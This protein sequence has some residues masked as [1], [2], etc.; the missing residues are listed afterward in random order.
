M[1]AERKPVEP[2]TLLLLLGGG[3]LLFLVGTICGALI[4]GR[5]IGPESP[6]PAAPQIVIA[7]ATPAP[8]TST[9][10]PG[11]TLADG[12]FCSTTPA[13]WSPY[14]VQP[15][16][17]LSE[18]VAQAGVSQAIVLQANCLTSPELLAGQ[19]L[20]LPP[21]PTP[22]P[23]RAAPPSGWTLYT[24]QMG[25]TLSGL[26]TARQTTVDAVSQVN[27]LTS[28]TLVAGQ[29]LYL[30]A[31]PTPTPCVLSLPSNWGSYTVQ[32]DDTLFS[33]AAA[34]GATVEQVVRVN[35][36]A[37]TEI[38]VGQV[39]YLPL[40]PAPTSTPFA[41]PTPIL[42]P[43]PMAAPVAPSTVVAQAIP[44]M[45]QPAPAAGQPQ[46]PG[47]GGVQSDQMAAAESIFSAPRGLFATRTG[48]PGGPFDP[49]EVTQIE[50][51]PCT[52]ADQLWQENGTPWLVV[53]PE[54]KKQTDMLYEVEQGGRVYIYVCGYTDPTGLKAWIIGPEQIFYPLAVQLYL[55]PAERRYE[56][57]LWTAQGVVVWSTACDL[58]TG[59]YRLFVEN[60]QGLRT[61]EVT[62]ELGPSSKPR[63][64]VVPN[65]T[66]AGQP[67]EFYYCGYPPPTP[68]D[69]SLLAE[70]GRVRNPL[71]MTQ[72]ELL[73]VFSTIRKWTVTPS[74]AQ[75]AKQ[76]FWSSPEDPP[77]RYR[78][79]QTNDQKIY[80]DFW[81]LR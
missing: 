47:L 59:K 74:A 24:V 7:T 11:R 13:D 18:L 25:D 52:E 64:L 16:D 17:T 65:V 66:L 22:G 53:D 56:E 51:P 15:G 5:I 2:R 42:Q 43:T 75:W 79:E 14:T 76:T 69:L 12:T 1:A 26:T 57:K 60:S 23:C 62:F 45:G 78:L 38:Q 34:R 19:A 3:A 44:S 72:K 37:S 70:T 54:T 77:G 71:D 20:Y 30:P 61:E 46:S 80:D 39:L 81:L 10:T 4:W 8:M 21:T 31:L 50:F 63:I 33:L 32:P 36:L 55:S 73:P 29:T 49:K 35:C 6:T 27:C 9:S 41:P 40:L 67:F 48:A 68:I 58:P 28:S